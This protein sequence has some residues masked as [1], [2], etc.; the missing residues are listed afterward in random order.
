MSS[1][2]R[3]DKHGIAVLL[4]KVLCGWDRLGM[5]TYAAHGTETVMRHEASRLAQT[6]AFLEDGLEPRRL[7]EIGTGYLTLAITL[8]HRFPEAEVIGVEHPRRPYVW[9]P[10]Y[11]ARVTEERIRLVAADLVGSGLPFRSQTF[12]VAVFAEVVE[13]LPP[14]AVPAALAEIGRILVP[15]GVLVLTTPNLAAWTNREFLLR[16]HSPQQSPSR[17]IDGTYGHLRLYTMAELVTLLEES[18]FKVVQRTF[19]DQVAV[20][21]SPIRRLLRATLW[22]ARVFWPSLRDTC[23]VRAV[24]V[25]DGVEVGSRGG[26]SP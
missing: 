3:M 17:I 24:R 23:M 6:L 4:G 7:V 9:L 19:I 12:D 10:E 13:H 11:R 26:K 5:E 21:I 16:G 8:R 18:G 25:E 22:P 14:N 2:G 20:G 15:S 1:H